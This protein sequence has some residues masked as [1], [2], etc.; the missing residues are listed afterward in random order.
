MSKEITY[1]VKAWYEK[2]VIPTYGIGK[3]EKNPMFL[4]K[5]VY[6]GSSG[7][8]YPHPVIEKI[9]DT[10]KDTEW[11]AVFIENQYLKI[12]ILPELGGRIQMAYDKIKERHFVYYNNVIKPALVGL[13]GPWISGGIEFNWPQHHRPSTYDPT[14]SKIEHN[15]DGSITVWCNELERMFRTRGMAGFTLHP[16]KAYI[17]IKVKL[18]NRTNHPQTFLWWANPAVKVNDDYQSVF[19]PDVNAV[20]DHGKRDVSEFPIAKGTY[21]KVD[22]SPGTDISRYKNIPV[23]TSYM[24]INSDYNFVGGYEND[25]KGGL[26]H[27][28]NHHVSPGKKQWTWGHGD[29]GQAWDRNLTDED[30]PYIELMCGVYTDNQPDFTWLMP[31]EEKTFNQYFMPYRDL[32]VVKNATKEAMLNL[33]TDNG[34]TT[35]KIYTTAPYPAGKVLLTAADKVILDKTFDFH[36]GTS[37]EKIVELPRG[38]NEEDLEISVKTA[39]GITLVDWSA[40]PLKEREIPEAAKAA[41]QPGEIKSNEQLY[42]TGLHLEQYRHATYDPR[43]YYEEVL[44]RDAGDSRCNNALGLWYLRRG[45]FAKAEQYFQTAIETLT[46]RNPNPIDGEPFFNLGIAQRYLGKTQE[47]Y[48]AFYKSVWNAAWMDSGYFQIARIETVNKKWDA[49]L[50]VIDRSLIRNWHNHKARQL[51]VSILRQLGKT[52]EALTLIEDSLQLDGFNYSLFFEKY[53]IDKDEQALTEMKKLIRANIHNYIEFALDYAY[54]GLYEEAIQFIELGIKEQTGDIYPL[55]YYY[56]AWFQ[57]ESGNESEAK[58]TLKIAV[59]QNPDYCFPNQPE[60][61]VALEKA[62]EIQT[63]DD[64]ALYYLGNFWYAFKNYNEA[65]KCW[66]A[67]IK[68]NPNFPTTQRNLALAYFNKL[69]DADKALKTLEKAFELDPSDA[70]V[71]MEL[72]Q[73]YKRLNHDPKMRLKMLEENRDLCVQRDD[74]YLELVTL[75]NTAGEFQVAYDL[76]MA[77][78]FHP[79]EGGEGKVT[80]QYILSLTELGKQAI[81]NKDYSK[82]I[83]LLTNSR[84]YPEN[85]GE[86]KLFGTQENETLYWLGVA[87]QEMRADV[88]AQQFYEEAA[89]GLEQVSAAM[90]Y[91]D[92][93]PD[94]IFYQGLALQ[95][96]DKQVEAEKKFSQLIDFGTIHQ[97]DKIQIDYF[98]VSLPDLLIWEDDLDVRNYQLCQY[99]LALG[100]LGIGNKFKAQQAI[101]EVLNIDQTH[102]GATVAKSLNESILTE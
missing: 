98:A 27:V 2:V 90:F 12:M 56:L 45:Q 78:Q 23:P 46:D 29:F 39:E 62:I 22:Y 13:T 18:Y 93:Q 6:Q 25:T 30:G 54:A 71:L 55:A 50:E 80:R 61:V 35:I 41:K 65:I 7:V 44:K 97:N 33:E 26:L 66:E 74:L 91:N 76:I 49:A 99:L 52:K 59:Q 95:R 96:L 43:P 68:I 69:N 24:A 36:P 8:V 34:Q 82:A 79:W 63:E 75:Y 42:L 60:A 32:G 37:Y 84:T 14:D 38:I 89:K 73:L 83:E 81:Q 40:K 4:E 51:K 67:S 102:I 19:P 100:N 48:N 21:Y 72:D 16:E 87:H 9:E 28:A 10:K 101:E 64:K 17:E 88:E 20:F 5:R 70:R 86:G 3:P 94:T 1:E 57:S 31:G 92:Q 58:A 77:R 53:L 15:D 85:L 11:N 47:A